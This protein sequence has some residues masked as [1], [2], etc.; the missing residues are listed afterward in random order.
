MLAP[1]S[2]TLV[3]LWWSCF[4]RNT[5]SAKRHASA[6]SPG[7]SVCDSKKRRNSQAF[8]SCAARD[9][10]QFSKVSSIATMHRQFRRELTFSSWLILAS[11]L[12]FSPHSIHSCVCARVCVCAREC[13][14]VYVYVCVCV[15][16]CLCESV[17]GIGW[18]GVRVWVH[19]CVNAFIHD[20]NRIDRETVRWS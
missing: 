16:V 6:R 3:A 11:L 14:C 18:V 9:W 17:C 19:V 2:C 5:I 13:V 1:L 15:C 8:P 7:R 12:I 10:F 20:V 4:Q